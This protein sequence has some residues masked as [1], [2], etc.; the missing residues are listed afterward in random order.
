[1]S[2]NTL[3]YIPQI[4]IRN[5]GLVAVLLLVV[6]CMSLY[7]RESVDIILLRLACVP[8]L[9]LASRGVRAL[10]IANHRAQGHRKSCRVHGA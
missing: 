2:E 7:T 5:Y 3:K 1:M 4:A 10:S 9:F 6:L 8:L